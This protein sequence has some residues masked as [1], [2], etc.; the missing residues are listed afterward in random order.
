MVGALRI[1]PA[2]EVLVG[3]MNFVAELHEDLLVE[4]SEKPL[5]LANVESIAHGTR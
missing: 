1:S 3:F 4:E 2:S 5:V